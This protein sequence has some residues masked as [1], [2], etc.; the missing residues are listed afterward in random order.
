[1]GCSYE[2]KENLPAVIR[3]KQT[4][5]RLI[6]TWLFYFVG[7]KVHNIFDII[8]LLAGKCWFTAQFHVFFAVFS[9]VAAVPPQR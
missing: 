4:G 8:G 6:E 5:R 2:I 9:V 1:M 7:A 3:D